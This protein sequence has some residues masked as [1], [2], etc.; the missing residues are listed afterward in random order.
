M[1]VAVYG[2][3]LTTLVKMEGTKIPGVI[4]DCIQEVENRGMSSVTMATEGAWHECMWCCVGVEVE[5]LYRMSGKKNEVLRLKNK[6]DTGES[7][8][9]HMYIT[10]MSHVQQGQ[11]QKK[12]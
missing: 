3:E 9:C 6:F 1:Y 8:A 10:C 12:I 2:V 11:I 5:G 4:K 7:H